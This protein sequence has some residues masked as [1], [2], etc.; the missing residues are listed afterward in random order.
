M[1]LAGGS[2]EYSGRGGFGK[3]PTIGM[4]LDY[5]AFDGRAGI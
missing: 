2:R 5:S 1:K 3:G 4:D